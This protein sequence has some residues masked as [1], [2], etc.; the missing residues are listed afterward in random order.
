MKDP[1][2]ESS[3]RFQRLTQSLIIATN[4]G[5]RTANTAR[6][7]HATFFENASACQITQ[8]SG[9]V[10]STDPTTEAMTGPGPDHDD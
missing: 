10:Q 4:T 8:T 5:S 7:S 9:N 1:Q 6:N 2:T 3:N